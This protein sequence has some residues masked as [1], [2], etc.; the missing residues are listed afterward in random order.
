M[1]QWTLSGFSSSGNSV[2]KTGATGWNTNEYARSVEEVTVGDKIIVLEFDGGNTGGAM[3]GFNYGSPTG[4]TSGNPND[5]SFY[6]ASVYGEIYENGS[7]ASTVGGTTPSSTDRHKITIDVDG[8]VKYYIDNVELY[9]STNTASGTY[10]VNAH[11]YGQNNSVSNIEL[12]YI[13]T[14]PTASTTGVIDTNIVIDWNGQGDNNVHYA[15]VDLGS[16]L[17]D[18]NWVLR[19]TNEITAIS[20]TG[21]TAGNW[22]VIGLGDSSNISARDTGQDFIGVLFRDDGGSATNDDMSAMDSD[23]STDVIYDGVDTW[24]SG[25]YSSN[26]ST[27]THNTEIIRTSAT[28]YTVNMYNADW[29][30]VIDTWGGTTNSNNDGLRYFTV[31]TSQ[32]FNTGSPAFTGQVTNVQVWD[33]VTSATGTPKTF[34]NLGTPVGSRVTFGTGNALATEPIGELLK[35]NDVTFNVGTTSASVEENTEF[36]EDFSSY[37]TQTSADNAW[38]TSD[39]NI[40]VNISNDNID[41]YS[42]ANGSNDSIVY[43]LGVG[44]V[45]DDKWKLRWDVTFSSLTRGLGYFVVGLYDSD[46]TVS[47]STNQKGIGLLWTYHPSVASAYKMELI[48]VQVQHIILNL[49]D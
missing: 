2:T 6:L 19:F 31:D 15:K 47:Y 24:S 42:D 27:G 9:E 22:M 44:T 5:F 40:R 39:N 1:T 13:E 38:S 28:A 41:I 32:N 26:L 8:T 18:T 17:S 14:N 36:I 37:S 4:F 29:S 16:A 7:Q 30:S 49:K 21:G 10:Y 23:G 25:T 34:D 45:P 43:D 11:A 12:Y 35:L 46:E 3:F 33:G 48:G 20:A